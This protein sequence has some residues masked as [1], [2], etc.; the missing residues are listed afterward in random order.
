MRQYLNHFKQHPKQLF[1]VDALGAIISALLLYVLL[2]PY[3]EWVGLPAAHIKALA[4]GAVCLAGYDLLARA[5]FTTERKW[6]LSVIA[7][8][9]TSY[10]VITSGVLIANYS[11]ITLVGWAYFIGEMAIV[12]VLVY[13][14]WRVSVT[15]RH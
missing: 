13:L 10:C 7:L 2:M 14:E 8:L 5:V 9:N 4:I 12:A 15:P 6:T 1:L 11:K 3:A